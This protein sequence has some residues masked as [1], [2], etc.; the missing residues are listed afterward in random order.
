MREGVDRFD[1]AQRSAVDVARKA[2]AVQR[3]DDEIGLV[4]REAL[5]GANRPLPTLRRPRRVAAE[6]RAVAEQRQ[7]DRISPGLQQA[8][9]DEAVAAVAA[10][11]AQNGDPAAA[12][13][14]ARGLPRDR[15]TSALHQRNARRSAGDGEPIDFGHLGRS[16]QFGMTARIKHGAI[17]GAAPEARQGLA[18]P[19]G[20]L[21][22]SIARFSAISRRRSGLIPD[23]SA[24]RAFDC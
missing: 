12:R 9:G 23:S 22:L 19:Q 2:G 21:A 17:I 24:G 4:E 5:A 18:P 7:F 1:E 3:V 16:Q 11:P 8:R 20:K 10:R 15:H 13:R 6:A 14:Q